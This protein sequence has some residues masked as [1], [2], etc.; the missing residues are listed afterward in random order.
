[1]KSLVVVESGAKATKIKA[2]LEK[3]F[4]LDEW[5]VEPC[6]GHFRDLPDDETAVNPENWLDLKWQ[7]TPKGKKLLK[8]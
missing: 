2:Y 4:P 6:L 7:E 1:M 5:Q 3:S 8:S